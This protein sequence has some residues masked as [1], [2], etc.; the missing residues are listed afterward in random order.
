MTKHATF[1]SAV[2]L[3][4]VSTVS[5]AQAPVPLINQPL[6]PDVI[7]PGGPQFTLTVNGTGFVSNSSVNWNRSPL[8]TQ[9][10]S[11]S[12][13]TATV[14]AASI[15]K[16]GSAEITVAN[17][18]PGGGDS[19]AIAFEI[20]YPLTVG[21]FNSSE[22]PAR[23]AADSVAVGDFNGDG[24]LDIAVASL[25]DATVSVYLGDGHGGFQYRG[26][27][28]AGSDAL[29]VGD[30]NGDGK[31]DLAVRGGSVL[32]GNGDGTFQPPIPFSGGDQ[33][34]AVGDFNDDGKLDLASSDYSGV[35]YISLGNGD[36][37]FQAP[38]AYNAGSSPWGIAVGDFNG[39]GKLDLATALTGES[40]VGIL[41]GNG[42]GTFQPVVK[43]PV[44]GGTLWEI[45]TADLNGDGVL[46]LVEPVQQGMAVLLGNGDGT[47]RPSV[48]YP[49]TGSN[50]G[51]GGVADVN[52]DG[53]PDLVLSSGWSGGESLFVLLG[54]GDGTFQK[55]RQCTIG[56]NSPFGIA[57]GDFNKD[58]ILDIVAADM[59]SNQISVE[60]GAVV[61]LD[62]DALDFGTVSV[63]NQATLASKLTNIRKVP[64]NIKSISIAGVS[65]VFS[66]TNNCGTSV[67]GGQSCSIDVTFTPPEAGFFIAAVRIDDGAPGT[68]QLILL[69]GKGSSGEQVSTGSNKTKP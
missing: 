17:P 9:F 37:T 59:G 45:Y 25:D 18:G 55:P 19:N 36:G 60:L 38:V 57:F 67:G 7:A 3:A 64:L 51:R 4:F 20:T 34:L 35:I 61:A 46:D 32:L 31:L 21:T 22:Y 27:Y 41:L 52:G 66:Q 14:P 58:G 63:G 24:N 5:Y 13:L 30:F 65:G 47:F 42:D 44:N 26:D 56:G 23:N 10:I 49:V 33:G 40:A 69:V 15:A 48:E 1:L 2:L 39:D 29:V 16:L 28:R 6:I 8:A 62:P 12:Q 50:D 43:Y 54:N 68:P 53:I 11:P